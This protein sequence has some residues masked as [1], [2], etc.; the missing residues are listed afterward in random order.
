MRALCCSQAGQNSR[1]QLREDPPGS[2]QAAKPQWG[3]RCPGCFNDPES[4]DST[5]HF[6]LQQEVS[7]SRCGHPS[8]HGRWA[9]A[10]GSVCLSRPP[11]AALRLGWRAPP[12]TLVHTGT[13]T[14]AVLWD[15]FRGEAGVACPQ[16]PEL[17]AVVMA[18]W[19]RVSS[20]CLRGALMVSCASQNQP[21]ES[22]CS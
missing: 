13:G 14:L 16:R 3:R 8:L 7:A 9:P 1:L 5:D 2:F 22:L 15:C 17:W 11:W 20:V 4:E 10:C 21:R 18:V 19:I 12:R 6:W